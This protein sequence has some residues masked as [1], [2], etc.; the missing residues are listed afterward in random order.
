M[1]LAIDSVVHLAIRTSDLDRSLG[2]Y[3]DTLG[4]PEMMRHFYTDGSVLCVFVRASERQ[5]IEI[6]PNGEGEVAGPNGVGLD[7]VCFVVPD[8][9]QTEQ[10]LGALGVELTKIFD[11][12]HGRTLFIA[13]PDG[14]TIEFEGRR[15]AVAEIIA[16]DQVHEGGSPTEVQTA[17]IAPAAK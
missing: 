13:D 10:T 15:A 1:S 7:H 6:F 11:T 5:Y 2:F 4:F 14:N 17:F 9:E 16:A 12:P 8:V 3:R